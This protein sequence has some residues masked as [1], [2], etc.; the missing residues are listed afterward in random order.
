LSHA[1]YSWLS[2]TLG[3][4]LVAILDLRA[5]LTNFPEVLGKANLWILRP[6][7]R[8][9]SIGGGRN[10][11]YINRQA[12]GITGNPKRHPQQQQYSN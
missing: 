11:I 7:N 1:Q 9:K 10:I 12:F 5:L 6:G 3:L 2:D 8:E 4:G